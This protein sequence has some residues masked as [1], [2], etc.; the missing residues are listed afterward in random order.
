MWYHLKIN[1]IFIDNNRSGKNPEQPIREKNP[2]QHIRKK[3]L[4][5]DAYFL[6][7]SSKYHDE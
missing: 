2:E 7:G 1:L 3:S 4:Q 6:W 5:K